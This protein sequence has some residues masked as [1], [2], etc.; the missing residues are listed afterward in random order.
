LILSFVLAF[1]I[2]PYTHMTML[3]E[4]RRINPKYVIMD[5]SVYNANPRVVNEAMIRIYEDP[6]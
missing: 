2:I 4:F 3:D 1:F 5:V 6:E